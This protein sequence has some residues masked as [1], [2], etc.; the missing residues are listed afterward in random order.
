MSLQPQAIPPIPEETAR[1]ACAIFPKGN[2]SMQLRDELGTIFTDEQFAALYPAGGQEAWQP[3][4]IALVLVMQFMENYTDRQAAEAMRTRIDWKYLLSLELTDPGFDFSVLSEFRQRVLAAGLE[5]VF[6]NTLLHLCRERGWLKERGK[7]RTDSTHVLAAIRT[8]N[9]LACV[10]ETLRATLHSL[11]V[12]VPDWL[13][14]QV[15]VEWDERYGTRTEEYR[16]PKESSKRQALTEQI[17]ADGWVLLSAIRSTDAPG[18]LAEVP[19]VEILRRVWVQQFWI[20]DGVIRW[21]GDQDIPPASIL[22][23]SPYDPEAHLSIKRSTVWTGYKVHLTET[24][25]EDLPHLLIHVETT[26]APT[27]DIEMTTSIHQALAD[28]QLL[29]AEHAMD[30]GYVNGA[31]LV[32]S[33]NT[34]GVD[35]LGPV[36]TSPSW[37]AHAG[38]GFDHTG[39]RIDWQAK[40]AICPQGNISRKWTLKQDDTV[41]EVI[42]IQ[43]G[44]QDCLACPCRSQCTTATS[45]P[46]QLVVRP[47][48]QFEAIQLARHRQQTQEFK[49]RY[50][51]RAGVEGTIS[52]A[53][54]CLRF[55]EKSLHWA[56]KDAY[57]ARDYRY[58][59]QRFSSSRLVDGCSARWHSCLTLCCTCRLSTSPT[60]SKMKRTQA[61][62]KP[63]SVIALQD[64]LCDTEP[65]R[66][67]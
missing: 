66:K 67:R 25:D 27:Q 51:I 57:T 48:A 6:L 3:W 46:R 38:Q 45:N 56:R 58:R 13:R 21:R 1:V 35:L 26:P 2:R 50:A 19:A 7:Q 49:D 24:C 5:E 30:T 65:K 18:W 63:S 28:K 9:R 12:V 34:Y 8:M 39:F 42:R 44:K 64:S 40:H 60:G 52:E 10:T 14:A 11:A 33:Q 41:P 53:C 17:G 37:Q 61:S 16:F 59:S 31:H 23:S 47:Q 54:S 15:P 62:Q 4:R 36:T 29:P 32:T 20:D 55:T 43:F 22:I